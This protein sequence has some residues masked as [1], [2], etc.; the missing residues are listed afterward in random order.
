VL[1]G[2]FVLRGDQAEESRLALNRRQIEEMSEAERQRLERNFDRWQSMSPTDQQK[3]REFGARLDQLK[4]ELGPVQTDYYGWLQ[5]IP[6]YRRDEL[7]KAQSVPAKVELVHDIVNDQLAT[8]LDS[9]SAEPQRF[10]RI[11]DVPLLSSPELD[12]VFRVVEYNLPTS[13]QKRLVDKDGEELQG[14]ERHLMLLQI[15]RSKF[16][17][18]Q[19]FVQNS[20]LMNA[21][22]EA[23]PPRARDVLPEGLERTSLVPRRNFVMLIITLSVKAEWER[24]VRS[25]TPTPDKLETFYSELPP[26]QQEQLLDLS[27]REFYEELSRRFYRAQMENR[28]DLNFE[29][30]QQILNPREPGRD[31]PFSGDRPLMDGAPL[32]RLRP[33]L[34]GRGLF[35]PPPG[36]RP[37]DGPPFNGERRP[38]EGGRFN[39]PGGERPG[40]VD[41][42]PEFRPPRE[43][44]G[45]RDD[46]PGPQ[47]D[48]PP[49]RDKERER[50]RENNF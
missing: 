29:Q 21:I 8:R 47:P 31:G 19:Q 46:P 33:R 41:G 13:E 22:I 11:G 15:V 1:C 27:S 35:A 37:G 49:P 5:T 17:G 26:E 20:T 38:E 3:W 34:D 2:P 30:I 44:D 42:R 9:P 14:L 12:S 24:R 4:A 16:G 48:P 7:R 25:F 43:G 6:G 23:L 18:P 10:G 50:A 28:V 45:P 32:D 40:N 39:P 36:G